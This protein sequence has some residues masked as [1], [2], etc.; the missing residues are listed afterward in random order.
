[1][2]R[3]TGHDTMAP[4]A[5]TGRAWERV[6]GLCR[7]YGLRPADLERFVRT[8]RVAWVPVA[9]FAAP[10]P[11]LAALV[12]YLHEQVRLDEQAIATLLHRDRRSVHAAF[13]CARRYAGALPRYGAP[14]WFPLDRL[15]DN[16]LRIEEHVVAYLWH[17]CGLRASDIAALMRRTPTRVRTMLRRVH[18]TPTTAI[19]RGNIIVEEG[20]KIAPASTR[21]SP[22]PNGTG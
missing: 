16:R 15:V 20:T 14:Y 1:M 22:P 18:A 4:P 2:Q 6:V 21:R 8:H 7:T 12:R 9:I 10:I 13:L 11:A 19:P 17:D 5:G 3:Q